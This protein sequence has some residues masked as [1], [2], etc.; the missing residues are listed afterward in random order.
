MAIVVTF[1]LVLRNSYSGLLRPCLLGWSVLTNALVLVA[2]TVPPLGKS[3]ATEVAR[4][5]PRTDVGAHVVHDVAQLGEVLAAR[6][7]LEHL[8]KATRLRVQ[9]L[10]FPETFAFSDPT[11]V[12][13]IFS[14]RGTLLFD[15]RLI[16]VTIVAILVCLL[17]VRAGRSG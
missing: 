10:H 3:L 1:N 17:G 11:Q 14:F 4:E 9:I 7:A 8:I 15:G 12:A 16:F 6:Q 2:V 5:G 13:L